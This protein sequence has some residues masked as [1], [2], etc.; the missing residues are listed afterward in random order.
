[1][2]QFYQD[3]AFF[4]CLSLNVNISAIRKVI[5]KIQIQWQAEW[6][7]LLTKSIWKQNS[8]LKLKIMSF[9]VKCHL[10]ELCQSCRYSISLVSL[11]YQ[12]ASQAGLVG[13]I[14]MI[15]IQVYKTYSTVSLIQPEICRVCL[16]RI[17]TEHLIKL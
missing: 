9:K 17:A 16:D 4:L 13:R 15:N 12:P 10:S 7:Y 5:W 8:V 14:I 3:N 11:F 1:M 6:S 2:I